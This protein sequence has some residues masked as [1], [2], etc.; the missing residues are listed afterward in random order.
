MPLTPKRSI[1][2]RLTPN[3]SLAAADLAATLLFAVEGASAAVIA[4]ADLFGILVIA[5]VT[6]LGGGMI[7]DVLIGDLPVAALQ[8][9]RYAALSFLGAAVVIVVYQ[10]VST[11]PAGLIT[12]LDA[13]GLGLFA[14]TGA[15]KALDHR[16]NGLAA[17]LLGTVTGCGGGVLRD[18][19]LNRTPVVLVAHI[20][21][22]AA[23]TAAVVMV[24]MTKSGAPRWLAMAVGA[25]TG[26]TLRLL[27]V[28][29]DWN[30]PTIG[31]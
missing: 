29:F 7:R 1:P 10:G 2:W 14:V 24:V 18:V 13:L 8:S 23:L 27:A 12:V 6:A 19:L 28:G 20:Y 25:A 4:H 9:V 30:L 16:M 21:A 5:F 3:G 17:A 11:I 26:V 31:S 22:V 15:A